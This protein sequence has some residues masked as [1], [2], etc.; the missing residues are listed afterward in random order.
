M[1]IPAGASRDEDDEVNLRY[2]EMPPL[3]DDIRAEAERAGVAFMWYSPTPICIYNPIPRAL[4]NKGCS[5]CDGLLSVSPA[6][7]VLPC[8]SWPEPVGNILSEGF[9]GI[10][11]STRGQWL[12]AKSF[13]DDLCASCGD[14]AACQGACPLYWRHFGRDELERHGV[15]HASSAC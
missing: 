3:L 11:Q 10:W 2:E 5:A 8:S 7:D 15:N 12:R 6:G 14:F 9:D 4:G 13:A 1:V